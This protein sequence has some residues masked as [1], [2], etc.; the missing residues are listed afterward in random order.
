MKTRNLL[1]IGVLVFVW[2]LLMNAPVAS[3]YAR[4]PPAASTARLYGLEG[5][6]GQGKAQS[7]ALNG[8]PLLQNLR[9]SFQPWW[10]PLLRASF[11][12]EGGGQDLQLKGR[13]ARVF[14]GFDITAEGGGSIK[15]LAAAGGF[16]FVPFDGLAH[17]D[18]DS[19]H[20]RKGFP[21]SASGVFELHGV[22][23]TLGSNPVALG[24]FKATISNQKPP[25][26]TSADGSIKVVIETLGGPLDA[27]GE[28]HLQTDHSYDY[29]LQFKAKDNADPAL[30][31]MLQSGGA[32]Q[33]DAGGYYHLRNRGIWAG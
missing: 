12:V 28:V 6:I 15:A 4:F 24:D 19:L 1:L 7:L 8:R 16:P 31:N 13:F 21:S 2:T 10:L 14:G 25:A 23:F 9:W 5:G 32:G 3:L 20:L 26:G 33:P 29:D 27:S 17:F 18:L 22:A 30:R 11:H